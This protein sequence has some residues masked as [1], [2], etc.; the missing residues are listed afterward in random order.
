MKCE[1]CGVE[2]K[3]TDKF[4][5]ICGTPNPNYTPDAPSEYSENAVNPVVL[6]DSDV[7][8]NEG[9]R[10]EDL[11]EVQTQA[12]EEQ[13][14]VGISTDE[15]YIGQHLA[16]SGEASETSETSETEKNAEPENVKEAENAEMTGVPVNN[17][18]RT[19]PRQGYYNNGFA[20]PPYNAP[21]AG[22]N[23]MNYQQQPKQ[24]EK[25]VCSLSAVVFCIVVILILSVACGVLGGMY[26]RERNHRLGISYG[27]S[28][29]SY[30][31]SE[32]A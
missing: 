19:L 24:K 25:R 18:N 29:T 20:P 26:L 11:T 17:P 15:N 32:N 9:L 31:Y 8:D 23:A 6:V 3:D 14:S 1:I 30:S 10:A 21:P 28:D 7:T 27:R 4:C 2:L 12:G 22:Y 13:Q 5:G 16:E